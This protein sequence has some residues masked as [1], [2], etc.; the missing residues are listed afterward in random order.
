MKR[1]PLCLLCLTL[2]LLLS[3]LHAFHLPLLPQ[4]PGDG[5]ADGLSKSGKPITAEGKV[6][7]ESIHEDYSY[8]ILSDAV[9]IQNKGTI[10][11]SNIRLSLD[12]S[13]SY[14]AG[15][16][17]RV[18]GNLEGVPAPTNP[19]QFDAQAYARIKGCRYLMKRP[20]VQV[21]NTHTAR[22]PEWMS[23][24]RGRLVERIEE[25]YPRRQAGILAA[26]LIGDKG[27]ME[28][29]DR[30]EWRIGG[31]S[32]MLVISGLHLSILGLFLWKLL[33]KCRLPDRVAAGETLLLLFAY[34]VLTGFAVST[35]RA[36]VMFGLVLGA[37]LTG[38]TYDPPTAAAAAALLILLDNPYYLFDAGF[39]L[40]FAAVGICFL[41]R[42]RSRLMLALMLYLGMLPLILSIFFEFPLYS[43]PIN[44]LAVPFLPIILGTGILGTLFGGWLALPAT[45]LLEAIH[46]LLNLTGSL[47]FASIIGG[48]PLLPALLTYL[49]LLIIWSYLMNRCRAYKRRL[50]FLPAIPLMILVLTFHPSWG[51]LRYLFLDTGQGDSCLITTPSKVSFLVDAGSSTVY[52]TGRN[53]ILPAIKYEGVR[54]IDYMIATHMDSDHVG[55]LMEILQKKIEREEQLEIGN[56]VLPYLKQRGD[57]YRQMEKLAKEAGA[58][59]LYLSKGDRLATGGV[60]LTVLGPDP[61]LETDPVD[62]NGQCLVLHIRY[63]RFDALLTGD[64]QGEGE[65][66]VIRSLGRNP[67][68]YEVLKVAH[69]GSGH[70]TPSE[71]LDQIR[72][73]AAL[74]SVGAGNRYG[75]PSPETIKRLKKA[76]CAIYRTDRCGAVSVETDGKTFKISPFLA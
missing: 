4:P 15:A 3:I 66:E 13:R 29:E 48:K 35:I 24:Q 28:E 65:K 18:T 49:L 50:F 57:A 20:K 59:V 32:H 19:G 37:R 42:R 16:L 62:E 45:L 1:R 67:D 9:L 10:K 47:P 70:S 53:R 52:E 71:L 31:I 21:V 75:H 36:F 7:S 64:V 41:F 23:R 8:C 43:I 60:T 73:A 74:I 55:G 14:G 6:L 61:E 30:N 51:K 34:S 46:R 33:K 63:G 68:R 40:S 69:H 26:M 39:E 72:P 25:V 38:R 27:E 58:R 22:L 54:R 11:I 44:L 76:G 12:G 56:V 17:L 5:Q 2:I